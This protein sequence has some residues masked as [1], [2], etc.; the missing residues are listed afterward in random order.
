MFIKWA[1]KDCCW[2]LAE[3]CA[4]LVIDDPLLRPRYGCIEFDSF[5]AWLRENKLAATFAFIPWNHARSDPKTV[6]LFREN[7]DKLSLCVHG[8]DH[9]KGEFSIRDAARLDAI[10]QTAMARMAKHEDRFRLRHDR[11]MVFPQGKFSIEALAALKRSGYMAAVNTSP[12]PVDYAGEF[13][14]HDLLDLAM[15]SPAGAPLFRRRY[16]VDLF[17]FACD[18]FFEKPA[19]IVQH[20]QDFR[21]GFG[22]LQAFIQDLRAI[23]PDLRWMPLGSLLARSDWQKRGNDGTLAVRK[24]I[25]EPVPG[26]PCAEMDYPFQDRAKI[27]F[28]RYL[29]EFRDTYVHPSASLSA[30]VAAI[31]R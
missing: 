25:G 6:A 17:G 29:S 5:L 20:H 12:F 9:T 1:L 15:T 23:Q 3:P 19:I 11:V 8:C 18:L 30:V 2:R 16:P 7:P 31:R 4:S 24:L 21:D 10:A 28:R 13:T 22:P 14:L 27:A 26:G